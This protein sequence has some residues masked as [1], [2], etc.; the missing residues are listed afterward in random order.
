MKS[1]VITEIAE[2]YFQYNYK[3]ISEHYKLRTY[4]KFKTSVGR[5]RYLDLEGLP[6]KKNRKPFCAFRISCHDLEIERG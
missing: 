2:I 6:Q 1:E 3:S 5:E 4:V